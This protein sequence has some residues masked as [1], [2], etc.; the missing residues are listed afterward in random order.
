M[1]EVANNPNSI[2]KKEKL[3]WQV[4]HNLPLCFYILKHFRYSVNI[5][6]QENQ[7]TKTFSKTHVSLYCISLTQH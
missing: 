5:S 1:K 4:I 7:L 2:G 6:N 3:K